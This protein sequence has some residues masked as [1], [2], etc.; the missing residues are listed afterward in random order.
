MAPLPSSRP[1]VR[2]VPAPEQVVLPQRVMTRS[3]TVKSE[4]EITGKPSVPMMIDDQLPWSLAEVMVVEVLPAEQ[5][6]LPHLV[7][8]RSR[9]VMSRCEITGKPSVPMAIEE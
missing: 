5:A 8:T 7:M 2:V 3:R 9:T 6:L 1:P 4:C